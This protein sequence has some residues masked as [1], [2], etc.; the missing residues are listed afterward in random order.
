MDL[1]LSNSAKEKIASLVSSE[2]GSFLRLSIQGGGCAG[3]SYNF[4]MDT[5]F[6]EDEDLI[7]DENGSKFVIDTVSHDLVKGSQIDYTDDLMWSGFVVKNPNAVSKC[8]CGS[9]FSV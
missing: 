2:P 9:S 3:F 7:L 1:T 8:G 6:L 5:V 4:L